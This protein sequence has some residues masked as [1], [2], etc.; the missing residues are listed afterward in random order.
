MLCC[1]FVSWL[2]M[3]QIILYVFI[4]SCVGNVLRFSC[5]AYSKS[6]SGC[7][8]FSTPNT[9][10]IGTYIL[11][12]YY[13]L[14]CYDSYVCRNIF[15]CFRLSFLLHT[16]LSWLSTLRFNGN[17]IFVILVRFLIL[18]FWRKFRKKK[19]T[20]IRMMLLARISCIK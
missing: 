1:W 4:V 9:Q 20:H 19:F 14:V 8:Y 16:I 3:Y 10:P 18:C 6:N 7:Q 5:N 12:I 13:A 17:C 15:T 2:M 11:G